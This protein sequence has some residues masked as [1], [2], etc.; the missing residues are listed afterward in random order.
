MFKTTMRTHS[1][2]ELRKSDMGKTVT[3]CGWAHRRRDH[4]GLIF[5]DLRDRYGLT[6]LVFDPAINSHAHKEAEELRSE[7]SIS[8]Q[9]RVRERAP[10]MANSKLL[11]GEIEIEVTSLK[12]LSKAKTPP[13]A[14]CEEDAELQEDLR[15]TYRYLDIRRGP[16]LNN[17]LM[18]HK[19]AMTIRKFFD[20]H[21]FIDVETPILTKSTPEGARDYIVPSRVHHGSFYALPQSP[22][23]FKQLLMISG[24][25]RY[26]QIAR[27]F[28]DEDLRADR[29]PEFTQV[30]VEMSYI[31]RQ[32]IMSLMEAMIKEVFKECIGLDISHTFRQISHQEAIER[33]GTDKPDLRFALDFIRI[34]EI[35]K[36]CNFTIFKEAIEQGGTVKAIKV[37]RGAE[38]ISRKDIENF[39]SFVASFGLKGL[40]WMKYTEEGLTSNIV[41]FFSPNLQQKLIEKVELKPGDLILFAAQDASTVNQALDH[42]RRHIATKLGLINPNHFEFLWVIDFPLF[43]LDPETKQISSVHHPF[44]APIDEDISLLDHDPLKI[45]AKA[46]DLVLNGCELGGGSIRIHDQNLQRKIFERLRLSDEAIE[47][48]FGFFIRALQYGTPPH[49]GLAFGLDR[50]AMLL[51]NSPS[52]RDVIAFPKTQKAADLM[53]EC[54]SQVSPEQLRDL[55]IRVTK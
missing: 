21:G 20:R 22:Q 48:K 53:V 45:R 30:D 33:Y 24:L 5:I 41:K 9:G 1:A 38:D 7:W 12:V 54:P 37:P 44:T 40:A 6:Q 13:F 27:C 29:Q 18:K 3:L 26:Y 49:G 31:D 47:T 11:T 17:L 8:I 55:A 46:Y 42:L 43:E 23:I 14:V 28:R 52:I 16:I 25:D 51:T 19:L 15:L 4:G 50:I 34:D 35:A 32:D 39:T 36:E 2:G 10:G